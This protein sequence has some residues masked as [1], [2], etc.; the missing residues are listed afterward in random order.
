[1]L[2]RLKSIFSPGILSKYE[3]TAAVSK[4]RLYALSSGRCRRTLRPVFIKQ[5]TEE[6]VEVE[7]KLDTLYRGRP[8]AETLLGLRHANLVRTIDVEANGAK[9]IEVLEGADGASLL[10]AL[11]QGMLTPQQLMD[12]VIAAGEGV[13]YLHSQGLL[14]RMLTPEGIT[15]SEA[16]A[17]VN[18]L[19]LLMD[20][21]KAKYAGTMSGATRY[22][23]PEIIKRA[24]A[25]ARSD[26]FSLGAILYESL[27][28]MPIFANAT[29]FERL[30]RVMNSKASS[31][32]DHNAYVDGELDR[33]VMKA[34]AR[35]PEE[36]YD[37][38]GEFLDELREAP[39]PE[40][41]GFH[42]PAYA[43]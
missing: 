13:G 37:A 34:V 3:T 10:D 33:V 41:L 21:E 9:R 4:H 24:P 16:G 18:D 39:V 7:R 14:H 36:R 26:I 22:S 5:Y 25:D 19:S 12:A 28:G 42:A 6:G 35:K 43:A 1:M 8:L 31:V 2:E 29:G 11:G 30:L 40:K 17:V 27:S 32:S 23:A 20:I 38:M 15:V